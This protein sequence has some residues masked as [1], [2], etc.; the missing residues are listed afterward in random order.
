MKRMR[1]MWVLAMVVGP[2]MATASMAQTPTIEKIELLGL[3][4]VFGTGI[5][6][7]F[8]SSIRMASGP[9]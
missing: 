6:T 8:R 1:T 4:R 7:R 2:F 3:N 9:N 5:R